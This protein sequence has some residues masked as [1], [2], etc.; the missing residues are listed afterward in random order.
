[1]CDVICCSSRYYDDS[2]TS[3]AAKF[4]NGI[5]DSSLFSLPTMVQ[6]HQHVYAMLLHTKIPKVQK[7]VLN[8]F[9][10]KSLQKV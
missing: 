3:P 6:F 8:V 10:L 4:F 5:V 1:V 9:I 2:A 7:D